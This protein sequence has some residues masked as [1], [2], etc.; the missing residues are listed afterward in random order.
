PEKVENIDHIRAM[1][2]SLKES[3]NRIGIHKENF[4]KQ[5][6]MG[7]Q[8]AAA[9]VIVFTFTNSELLVSGSDI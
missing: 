5:H 9:Q 7:L 4:A 2:Q 6:L 8:C 1:E 3:L